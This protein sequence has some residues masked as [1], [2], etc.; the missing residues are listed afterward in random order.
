MIS[1]LP[2]SIHTP[3]ILASLHDPADQHCL[4]CI[5]AEQH[6][7]PTMTLSGFVQHFGGWAATQLGHAVS[8]L[9]EQPHPPT[10]WFLTSFQ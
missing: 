10:H 8:C 9:T 7:H 5:M 6:P 4:M 1:I 2:N 3:A